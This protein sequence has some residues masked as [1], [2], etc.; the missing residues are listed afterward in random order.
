MITFEDNAVIRQPKM[1]VALGET[2]GAAE[3]QAVKTLEQKQNMTLSAMEKRLGHEIEAG[4]QFTLLT[5]A[6]AV[7]VP[8]GE[9]AEIRKMEGVK[10]AYVMPT[11][12][13]PGNQC[14]RGH[15]LRAQY[16]VRGSRHGCYL[17]LG[18]WL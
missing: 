11:F 18:L 8:Y 5:N 12:E 9:L 3:L 16:E 7:T 6:V 14:P 1:N 4:S 15:D 17:R 13:V 2:L 10:N